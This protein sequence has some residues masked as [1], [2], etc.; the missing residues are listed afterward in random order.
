MAADCFA[1]HFIKKDFGKADLIV[2]HLGKLGAEFIKKFFKEGHVGLSLS[3]AANNVGDFGLRIYK[4]VFKEG[5]VS[6][7]LSLAANYVGDFG[8]KGGGHSGV[9]TTPSSSPAT[10]ALAA[11]GT[12]SSLP[13]GVLQ[14]D[15]RR[16]WQPAQ[17]TCSLHRP[18]RSLP[19]RPPGSMVVP[20]PPA[21]TVT[22]PPMPALVQ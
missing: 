15:R 1:K 21:W 2:Q 22:Q 9:C 13:A 10:R 16:T 6:L 12:G 17:L 7:F 11:P 19:L 20:R 4:K 3:L 14:R 18:S 5:H 8:F